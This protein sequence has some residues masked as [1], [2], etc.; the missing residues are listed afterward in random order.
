[1][2]PT[3]PGGSQRSASGSD[4]GKLLFLS[5]ISEYVRFCVHPLRVGSLFPT[6]LPVSCTQALLA[7]KARYSAGSSSQCRT[8]HPHP[9]VGSSDPMLLGEILCSGD[10]PAFYRLPNHGYRSLLHLCLSYPP[11]CGHFFIS[12][13]LEHF[14]PNLRVIL[15]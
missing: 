5:W 8:P 14:F 4:S 10:Y 15:T 2:S 1:M 12:T 3:S 13:V 7:F 6:A 9:Q 11:H